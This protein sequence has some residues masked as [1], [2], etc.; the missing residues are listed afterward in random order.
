V[1]VSIILYN[2]YVEETMK[3]FIIILLLL[4]TSLFS[5]IVDADF[6]FKIAATNGYYS[7][8]KTGSE[9]TVKLLDTFSFEAKVFDIINVSGSLTTYFS[10]NKN[11]IYFKPTFSDYTVSAWIS[12]FNFDIGI[13]HTC[14]HPV[15]SNYVD[16]RDFDVSYDGAF[17]KVFI[18]YNLLNNEVFKIIPKVTY[19]L[20]SAFLNEDNGYV[21]YGIIK[22]Y[23]I[24]LSLEAL[25]FNIIRVKIKPEYNG[26]Y[27]ATFDFGIKIN[28][29]YVGITYSLMEP[30]IFDSD[31]KSNEKYIELYLELKGE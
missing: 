27:N 26:D 7:K 19:T 17:E 16:W 14:S 3:Y 15:M 5:D 1:K 21:L 13:L 18:E 24:S 8:N 30:F 20:K 2:I 10:K 12:L 6:G 22:D 23:N 11:N 25:L 4:S 28:D 29:L 9:T 31:L